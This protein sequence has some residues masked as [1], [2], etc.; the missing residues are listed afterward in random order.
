MGFEQKGWAK[1]R[2][3]AMEYKLESGNHFYKYIFYTHIDRRISV[4][5][6]IIYI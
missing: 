2:L 1:L 6:Y 3:S 4:Y 5:V